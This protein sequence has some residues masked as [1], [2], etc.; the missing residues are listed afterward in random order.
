MNID[1]LLKEIQSTGVLVTSANDPTLQFNATGENY[2]FSELLPEVTVDRNKYDEQDLIISDGGLANSSSR[3]APPQIKG[4]ASV[5]SLSVDLGNSSIASEITMAAYEALLNKLNNG[6]DMLA[7]AQI[8]DWF[9]KTITKP[10]AKLRE[11]ERVE[12][13]LKRRIDLVGAN[14]YA[15]PVEYLKPTGHDAVVNGAASAGWR[16]PAYNVMADIKAKAQLMSSKGFK[17]I[18]LITT[19]DINSGVFGVNN[20]IKAYGYTSFQN[21]AGGTLT[22][23]ALQPVQFIANAFLA[24]ELPSPEVYDL[25]YK[26]RQTGLFNKFMQD[27]LYD[28]LVLV[29]S[30]ER[31]STIQLAN[32]PVNILNTLGYTAIG[33]ATGQTSPGI[34]AQLKYV[35]DFKNSHIKSA[36]WQST[37][38]VI[39]ESEGYCVFKI[40]KV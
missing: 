33:V 34:A 15:I 16:D 21:P 40:P 3:Y 17:P 10:L 26:N 25:G 32:Q 24:N 6:A 9:N 37:F 12:S 8:I 20:A 2:L 30:T 4:G 29:G 11:F 35:D 14:G 7:V 23:P 28:Y 1:L 36:G 27:S 5:T 39:Q 19:S 31:S 13:I 18:R 38:P 22:L